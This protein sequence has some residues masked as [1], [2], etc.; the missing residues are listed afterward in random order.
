MIFP[1]FMQWWARQLLSLVPA[2]LM[3]R[4]A[5]RAPSTFIALPENGALRIV[6]HDG[7]HDEEIG[8]WGGDPDESAATKARFLAALGR[9]AIRAPLILMVEPDT[10]MQRV[11]TLPLA[12]AQD[13]DAVL[14][15]E[16]DRLTPF[17]SGALL[18]HHDILRRDPY[19]GQIHLRLSLI[20]RDSVAPTIESLTRLGRYPDRISDATGASITLPRI[21]SLR[22]RLQ[23]GRVLKLAGAITALLTAGVA[24]FWIQSAR[25]GRLERDISALRAPALEASQLRQRIET[26]QEGDRLVRNARAKLGDPVEILARL[27][28]LLPDNAYLTD[29]NLKQGELLI[30]G[31][32]SDPAGL[33]QA[34][35]ATP[36]LRDPG[37]IAPV[38]RLSGQTASQFSI[39]AE[40]GTKPASSR[41]GGHP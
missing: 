41:H 34:M 3:R 17:E 2:R 12:A 20:L 39:R 33:I 8:L 18:W 27:T 16:M 37:F 5:S 29:L 36:G 4:L 40:I 35:S 32:S 14:A 7:L 24:L 19:L 6:L 9:R 23:D 25:I 15:F 21:V 22:E 13:L 30:S 31:S 1:V 11:V 38:T 28:Q 10:I 26:R